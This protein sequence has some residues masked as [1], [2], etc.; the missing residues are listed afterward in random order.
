MTRNG[1]LTILAFF[2]IFIGGVSVSYFLMKPVQ[3]LKIYSPSDL[4]PKLVDEETLNRNSEHT[5]SPFS[6][7]NQNG[8]LIT[9]KVLSDKIYV[10]DFFFT[11]C[12][13]I[14]PKMSKQML[15]VF[16]KYKDNSKIMLVSHTVMPEVDSVPVLKDYAARY[17]INSDNKWLF[18]TGD[19]K[20]I[21]RLARK[22]YF[23]AINEGIGD[24]ND[25]IHTE[26]F[27]LVDT[28][29]RIRGFY[30][31]TNKEEVEKLIDDIEILLHEN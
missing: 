27:V 29:K 26:N 24:K 19:K 9:E 18:L 25:F 5:I 10:A 4:N 14:C 15:R 8:K 2:I 30:D 23:A 7:Y 1:L 6:L 12:P 17:G 16:D 31:G 3:K 13:S 28:K 21:Y 20:E 22:S 11:T